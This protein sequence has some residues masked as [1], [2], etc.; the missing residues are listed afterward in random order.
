MSFESLTDEKIAELI[1][2]PKAA[3][4]DDVKEKRK[5]MHLQKNYEIIAKSDK[6]I[7]FELFTRQNMEMAEDF[8][9]GIR[10]LAPG[11]EDMI[12]VRYNGS[13]HPHPN[14]IERNRLEFA[15]HIHRTTERYIEIGKPD[16][17]AEI[18]DR[19]TTMNGAFNCLL[20][21]CNVEGVG[22]LQEELF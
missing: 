17:F 13:S 10:W 2:M 6:N 8:S 16:G 14:K 7:R 18:T 20:R 12:L 11:G 4:N 1:G 9:C 21:D 3:V 5:G 19:Y 15:N 22:S